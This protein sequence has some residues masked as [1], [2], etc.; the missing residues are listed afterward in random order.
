MPM[1]GACNKCP[2]VTIELRSKDLDVQAREQFRA[3]FSCQ[4]DRMVANGNSVGCSCRGGIYFA[5]RR[6]FA[7]PQILKSSQQVALL[8]K[9]EVKSIFYILCSLWKS[10]WLKKS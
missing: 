7:K 4:N 1:L 9:P 10:L 8:G 3:S 5:Y 2:V 6:S